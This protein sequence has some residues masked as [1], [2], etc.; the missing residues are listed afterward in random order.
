MQS[1]K[2]EHILS[3]VLGSNDS[4]LYH[5][6][7]S[8]LLFYLNTEYNPLIKLET[9]YYIHLNTSYIHIRRHVLESLKNIRNSQPNE[10]RK[11]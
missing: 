4:D 6:P 1:S 11:S 7:I 10:E 5:R 8:F 2:L 9:R 3:S